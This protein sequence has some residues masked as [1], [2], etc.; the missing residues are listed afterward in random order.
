MKIV[1]LM[2]AAAATALLAGAAHAQGMDSSQPVNP[3]PNTAT[4]TTDGAVRQSGM[5]NTMDPA[6]AAPASTTMAP[7]GTR[8]DVVSTS[9]PEQ[10]ATLKAGDANVVSNGPVADTPENRAKYGQPM[11][12]A[13]K[14]TDPAGN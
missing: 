11:S 4:S 7:T 10:Q 5:T 8:T 14:R 1:Q 9:S 13:G 2:T 12:R 3:T 6:M